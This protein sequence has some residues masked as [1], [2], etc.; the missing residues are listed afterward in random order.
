[1]LIMKTMKTYDH[2]FSIYSDLTVKKHE[3]PKPR[4]IWFDTPKR[5]IKV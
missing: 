2:Y 5:I 3:M 4:C 1:M